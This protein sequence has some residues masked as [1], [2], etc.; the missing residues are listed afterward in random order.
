MLTILFNFLPGFPEC[1]YARYGTHRVEE[2]KGYLPHS[3]KADTLRIRLHEAILMALEHNSTVTIQRLEPA[4][5]RSYVREKRADF[6]PSIT[7]SASRG[8]SKSQR[9]LGTQSLPFDMTDRSTEYDLAIEQ[10]VPTGTTISAGFSMGSSISSLYTD[11]Y[12]GRM[13]LTVTQALLQGFGTGWNLAEL[14]KAG[15]DVEIAQAELKAVAEQVVADIEKAYWEIYLTDR[16]VDIQ[17]KSLELARQQLNESLERVSVGKLPELELAAVRAEVANR[18]ETLIDARSDYEQARLGFIFLLNPPDRAGWHT[19]PVP[20]ETPFIPPDTLADI[21]IHAQLGS[22]YRAD[23]QQARLDLEKGILDLQQTRNGLLPKLDIFVT[24]GR[25]A[26]A[27]SF[28]DAVPEL[29]SPYY[30]ITAGM[31]LNFPLLRRAAKAEAAR[32]KW[33]KEQREL[34]LQNMERL[35][36]RDIHSAY[37]EVLRSRQK[38]EATRVT[39]QLQEQ[40]L[41][42]EQEKFRVGKST[43]LLLLQV[44]RDLTGSRL[45]EARSNVMFLNSLV[46]LYLMEGT[47]LERR[48]ID[49]G[50]LL[51][52]NHANEI[53]TSHSTIP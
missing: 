46:Q 26:Y 14:R 23:L 28:R 2:V 30:D 20:V 43:N 9:R 1:V 37:I 36:Q 31:T 21:S 51:T 41:A 34:A 49:A 6:D 32:A 39:S 25:T 16:E 33:T 47:L 52:S 19:I 29:D 22:K 13:E 24:L 5:D 45:E 18:E 48:G 50:S 35:V 7:A 40:K 11:Q 27:E 12:A 53:T 4:V 38:V 42:A 8:R 3:E 15:V 10:F 44:Q 17:E